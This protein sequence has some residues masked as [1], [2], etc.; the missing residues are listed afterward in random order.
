MVIVGVGAYTLNFDSLATLELQGSDRVEF[1]CFPFRE[2]V[3][4]KIQMETVCRF[5]DYLG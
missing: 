1:P 5:K 4:Y 3:R 2:V